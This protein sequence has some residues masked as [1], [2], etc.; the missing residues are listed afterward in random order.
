M[1][2]MYVFVKCYRMVNIAPIENYSFS[3]EYERVSI[4]TSKSNSNRLGK[5]IFRWATTICEKKGHNNSNI[6]TKR[7]FSVIIKCDDEN[8]V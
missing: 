8:Y 1:K 3:V 7:N 4:V 2:I 5:Q 6:N